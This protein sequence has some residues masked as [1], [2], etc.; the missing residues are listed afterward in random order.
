MELDQETVYKISAFEQQAGELEQNI[1]FVEKQI[2]ELNQFLESLDSIAKSKE[3]EM[4]SSLGKGVFV[5]T[6]IKDKKLY[7]DAG[8]G[9]IIRK[10]PEE[11]AKIIESQVEKLNELK[12]QLISQRELYAHAMQELIR[13]IEA[14]HNK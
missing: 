1:E 13:D 6:E 2:H 10:T 4:L 14:K 3:T 8:A 12:S 5:K 11:A 7:V 9:V